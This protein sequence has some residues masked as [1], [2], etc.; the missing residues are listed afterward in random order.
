MKLENS[1]WTCAAPAVQLTV[2]K[3]IAQ[4]VMYRPSIFATSV[5]FT[6]ALFWVINA[7]FRPA[8]DSIIFHSVRFLNLHLRREQLKMCFQN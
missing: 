3:S 7:I 5:F 2:L 1:F 8:G 4:I 6:L